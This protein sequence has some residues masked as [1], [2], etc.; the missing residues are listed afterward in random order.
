M[1][2][3]SPPRVVAAGL[4]LAM[5]ITACG[6]QPPDGATLVRQSSQ[7][8]L[9]LKGFHFQ[10]QIT[11]FTGAGEPVQSAQGDAHPPDLQA[12]VILKEGAVLLEVEVIFV[13]DKI[14]LKSFTGGWQELTAFRSTGWLV[15]GDA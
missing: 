14:Y 4:A 2:A 5:A 3:G 7:R 1:R 8:M 11:G 10:M 12:K 9:G 15:R 6:P 13:A